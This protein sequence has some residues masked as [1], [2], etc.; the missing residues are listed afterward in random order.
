MENKAV[1]HGDNGF[2]LQFLWATT[3]L[4]NP[5]TPTGLSSSFW[6]VG[7]RSATDRARRSSLVTTNASPSRIRIQWQPQAALGSQL[8][9]LVHGKTSH[10]WHPSM[11]ESEHQNW[12]RGQLSMIFRSKKSLFIFFAIT[13]HLWKS[14]RFGWGS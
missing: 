1:L 12:Q 7:M 5:D 9:T 2:T 6:I 8:M 14:T 10:R 11:Y 3:I 4:K 13:T